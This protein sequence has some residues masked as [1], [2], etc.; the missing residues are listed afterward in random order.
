MKANNLTE[1]RKLFDARHGDGAAAE[2]E[3]LLVDQ[4]TT[5]RMIGQR[6]GFST[7]RVSQLVAQHFPMFRR[8]V[9]GN[10]QSRRASRG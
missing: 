3:R 5:F 10:I 9:A 7:Q 1:W 8:K 2:F 6:F 4:Q